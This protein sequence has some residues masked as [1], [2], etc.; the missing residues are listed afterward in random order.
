MILDFRLAAVG[1]T[2]GDSR[3][4]AVGVGHLRLQADRPSGNGSYWPFVAL[5][6]Y[7]RFLSDLASIKVLLELRRARQFF[8]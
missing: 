1:A 3:L 4:T 2:S 8:L 6:S 7:G 5:Y